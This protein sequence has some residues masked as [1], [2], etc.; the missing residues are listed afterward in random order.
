MPILSTALG[1][2]TDATT[3]TYLMLGQAGTSA[4]SIATNQTRLNALIAAGYPSNLFQV[5]PT[6][7]S[8]GAFVLDNNGASFYNAFQ[9]EIRRRISHGLTLQGS[10]VYGKAEANGSTNSTT[11]LLQPT[12]LRNLGDDRVVEPFD[13]RHALKLNGIYELPLR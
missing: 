8:G 9:I 5:N 4:N 13:I 12:T 3:A 11:D 10:Y 7:A 2:T 1:T 6:V